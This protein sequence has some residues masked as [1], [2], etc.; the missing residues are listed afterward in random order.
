MPQS[1]SLVIVH[2]VFNT[3]DRLPLRLHTTCEPEAREKLAGGATTGL[4]RIPPHLAPR[5]GARRER[6]AIRSCK[7]SSP[8]SRDPP[9]RDT[10]CD[11][12]RHSWGPASL[13][14]RLISF[15]P[16]VRDADRQHRKSFV[17]AAIQTTSPTP[18]GPFAG[19]CLTSTTSNGFPNRSEPFPRLFGRC[20]RT[21]RR[22][23]PHP[24]N[25]APECPAIR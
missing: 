8:P 7:T 18:R 13:Y 19:P 9:G 10:S 12:I 16:P 5:K 2:L 15:E 24:A 4:P 17:T 25:H 3:K 22:R 23:A 20:D 11:G 14:P 1:L 21:L 6:T